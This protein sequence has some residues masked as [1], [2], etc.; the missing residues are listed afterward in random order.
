MKRERVRSKHGF[1]GFGTFIL[2]W[3][4]GLISTFGILFGVGYWAY[5]SINIKKIE[6]W[7]KSEIT[8]NQGLEDLTLKKAVS[9][10]QGIN[11]NGSN[12]YSLAQL[13]EDFN[14]SLLD[15]SVY[16]IDLTKIKN[17]SLKNLKDAFDDTVD[18]ITFN[19]VL[20]F[21]ETDKDKMGVLNTILENNVTYYV[22]NGKLYTDDA[23]NTEVDFKYTI[24]D[25]TVE[26]ANGSHTISTSNG[27]Q[28]IKPRL[29]D[30]PL[31]NA[32]E[33]LSD[34]T[35]DLKIYQ[36]LDYERTGTEGNYEY[37]KDG[38]KM[39]GVMASL[40]EYTIDDLSD[41]NKFNDIYIY[42]VMG[43]N[44]L[45]NG[46]YSYIN[47]SDEEVKVTGAMRT[48]A[49]KTI[50]E[51]SDPYL[52]NNL[53]V[54]EVMGYYKHPTDGKY[55]EDSN[56]STPVEGIMTTIAGKKISELDD[57]GA[58]NDVTVADAMGYTISEGVVYDSNNNKVEGLFAHLADAKVSELSTRINT[59]ELG[60]V[61][62]IDKSEA[63]GIISALHGTKVEDLSKEETINNIY[64]YQVMDYTPV[65]GGGYTY[66][67]DG[68]TKAVEG[69]MKALAGKTI[70][71]LDSETT[72][73]NTLTLSEVLDVDVDD[74]S[75]PAIIKALATSTL[76]SLDDDIAGL[77]IY[78]IMGY[79]KHPTNGKYY[80]TYNPDTQEYSDEV[81]GIMGA[82]ADT[83]A[84]NIGSAING[85]TAVEVLGADCKILKII[86]ESVR[87][88]ILVTELSDRLVTDINNATI[89]ELVT[90]EIITGVDTTKASYTLIENKTI[91]EI[92]NMV[93]G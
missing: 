93:L 8:D 69:V 73:I 41:Q 92:I 33:S 84:N 25:D 60:Q 53:Y 65:E 75:T 22:H 90:N 56:Y 46:E 52:I 89:G 87:D 45:G 30:L 49:G 51:M 36:L 23:Y 79:Y 67:E 83:N 78:K 64:I 70:G 9:I 12:A 50:G 82:I 48:L 10:V 35:M 18:S 55:Y 74:D 66:N 61:L 3:F 19:N 20:S 76:G 14:L 4:I 16:G 38:N 42:E 57:A 5:T 47:D 27:V 80:E 28:S 63:S 32:V 68:T 43:Y 29:S 21:M 77:Q 39:S 11:K 72:G 31:N 59:L 34:S 26:F 6:K 17:S 81:T 85:L 2:G 91:L 88:T 15:D 44:D 62:D 13:E 37:I 24:V 7:T 86:D 1:K 71:E 54:H 40:A 58:F